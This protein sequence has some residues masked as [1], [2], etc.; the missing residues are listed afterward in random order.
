[1]LTKSKIHRLKEEFKAFDSD[2]NDSI[3]LL[4][5]LSALFAGR[6]ENRKNRFTMRPVEYLAASHEIHA[7]KNLIFD[8]YSKF[9]MLD[10]N[11][12]GFVSL[13]EL[14]SFFGIEAG[15]LRRHLTEI[16]KHIDFDG[17]GEIDFFEFLE[18]SLTRDGSPDLNPYVI[19]GSGVDMAPP[20]ALS[21]YAAA[22]Y[23]ATG[24]YTKILVIPDGGTCNNFSEYGFSQSADGVS[25]AVN[26]T[27]RDNIL[28]SRPDQE[29][30]QYPIE[31]GQRIEFIQDWNDRAQSAL[32][33]NETVPIP[34]FIEPLPNAQTQDIRRVIK[35]TADSTVQEVKLYES[36]VLL[37]TCVAN[38]GEWEY[39]P[40]A[41][42]SIGQHTLQ[43]LAVRDDV[44]SGRASLL[45][46]VIES[47]PF[48]EISSP[49]E[50]G[51]VG[52]SA[53][54]SGK[55]YQADRVRLSE[56]G[57]EI[58]TVSVSETRWSF[59]PS[60]GWAS[61]PHE[62]TA[63]AVSGDDSTG[64]DTVIFTVVD[65]DL[66]VTYVAN[67]GGWTDYESQKFIYSYDITLH[68]GPS[69][70]RN[71]NLGFGNLPQG[72][73]L[74][75]SFVD[76]FEQWGMVMS[77]GSNGSVLLGSRPDGSHVI[78]A[79]GQLTLTVQVLIPPA[80]QQDAYSML[81]GLF[82]NSLAVSTP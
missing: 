46:S 36:T 80:T 16:F 8:Y 2:A 42:W 62:V 26:N 21:L 65:Q 53:S 34:V 25:S 70:V 78:P 63:V 47:T 24:S 39:H 9:R 23:N 29:G 81:Y 50:G 38:G 77:D 76:T 1:M 59:T 54:L 17:D 74:Y 28:F 55:A 64:P 4:E 72:S 75:Q 61:G 66:E 43:A 51:E 40:T 13:E 27:S 67:A 68:A 41:D 30:E 12:D 35:G 69:I 82:A 45:F 57:V 18:I 5:I 52:V 48:V 32:A 22:N 10:E 58:G 49:V 31:A 79:D 56:G 3:D 15:E 33:F 7:D 19:N 20:G 14:S 37:G 44:Q 11:H 60:E 71:W 73:K 6:A